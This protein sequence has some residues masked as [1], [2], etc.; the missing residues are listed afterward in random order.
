MTRWVEVYPAAVGPAFSIPNDPVKGIPVQLVALEL[1]QL[2]KCC[3]AARA[4][5]QLAP[6]NRPR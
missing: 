5:A 4:W 1:P 2:L 6:A 3:Y